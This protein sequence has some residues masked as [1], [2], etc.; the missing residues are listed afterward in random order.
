ML[1]CNERTIG[2]AMERG[3]KVRTQSGH[4]AETTGFARRGLESWDGPYR[5]YEKL[6]AEY[7]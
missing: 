6:N 4:L 7:S 2:G 3:T 5:I 1:K